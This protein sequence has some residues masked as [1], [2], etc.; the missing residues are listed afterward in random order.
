MRYDKTET[1]ERVN[2]ALRRLAT[3]SSLSVA[4]PSPESVKV[5][6]N[7]GYDVLI[8]NLEPSLRKFIAEHML[9]G[10][11]GEDWRSQ[12]P[13]SVVFGLRARTGNP[14]IQQ[15]STVAE[16]LENVYFLNL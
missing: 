13:E 11:F 14:N 7:Q 5:T 6:R 9:L 2:H 3:W 8:N 4:K 10:N 15:S 16:L 1:R 12:I